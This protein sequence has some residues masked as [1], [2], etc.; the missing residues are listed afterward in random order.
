MLNTAL[1]EMSKHNDVKRNSFITNANSLMPRFSIKSRSTVRPSIRSSLRQS[2]RP[3]LRSSRNT[4]RRSTIWPQSVMSQID[5]VDEDLNES[6]LHNRELPNTRIMNPNQSP[7]KKEA[8]KEPINDLVD[9]IMNQRET[10]IIN[11][12]RNTD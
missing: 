9:E 8:A 10:D 12:E 2:V 7:Q 1:V 11:S 6:A 5:D 4:N 3:Q